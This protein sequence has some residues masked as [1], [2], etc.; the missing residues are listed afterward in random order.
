MSNT[1]RTDAAAIGFAR[2]LIDK[3][4]PDNPKFET[5]E[6]IPSDFARALERQLAEVTA[7]RDGW[8]LNYESADK[9]L[10]LVNKL[11]ETAE[12]RVRE[13]EGEKEAVEDERQF[14]IERLQF[15]EGHSCGGDCLAA[16]C[17]GCDGTM[18]VSGQ[19]EHLKQELNDMTERATYAEG[20]VKELEPDAKRGKHDGVQHRL[21]KMHHADAMELWKALNDLSFECDG[22]T[23]TVAPTRE[24]YNR[25]FSVM[26][27]HRQAYSEKAR[28]NSANSQTALSEG[29]AK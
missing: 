4:T 1:P 10:Q 24:T 2:V 22:V 14:F 25:T 19:G 13:L 17:G 20:R 12:R 11:K 28:S 3:G 21:I 26:Q 8:K 6:I 18:F 5:T 7:E 29:S 27:K 9:N 15:W 16:P 23:S